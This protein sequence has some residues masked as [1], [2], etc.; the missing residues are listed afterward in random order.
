MY[1]NSSDYFVNKS[2]RKKT[3]V[4]DFRHAENIH[5][6]REIFPP[7]K[8]QHFFAHDISKYR[9]MNYNIET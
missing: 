1:Y 5:C 2:S 6:D 7:L 8:L 4:P 3:E 9:H